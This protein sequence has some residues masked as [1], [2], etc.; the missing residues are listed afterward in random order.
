MAKKKLAPELKKSQPLQ[1]VTKTLEARLA[2]EVETHLKHLVDA[3][4][5]V[6]Q[7]NPAFKIFKLAGWKRLMARLG[8]DAARAAARA[9]AGGR[10]SVRR[11]RK[12]AG[13]PKAQLT[14]SEQKVMAFIGK[15]ERGTQ[16]IARCIGTQ[17]ISNTL[18]RMKNKGAIA[19]RFEGQKKFWHQA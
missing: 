9:R 16:A 17:N 12:A 5:N 19:E 7:I 10:A 8:A 18:T 4:D 11:G 6:R 2:T 15:G 1:A 14:P 3:V 13:G